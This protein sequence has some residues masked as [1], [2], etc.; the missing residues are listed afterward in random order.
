[1]KDSVAFS[2]MTLGEFA[3]K[4]LI[5]HFLKMIYKWLIQNSFQQNSKFYIYMKNQ[6]DAEIEISFKISKESVRQTQKDKYFLII[7]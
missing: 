4:R 1:V 3:L 5:Y 7:Y 2:I 6:H